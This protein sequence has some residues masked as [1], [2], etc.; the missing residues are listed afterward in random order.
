MCHVVCHPEG[1]VSL[2]I[3]EKI[4]PK[5][6][7]FTEIRTRDSFRVCDRSSCNLF[8]DSN[9]FCL[10]AVLLVCLVLELRKTSSAR[11]EPRTVFGVVAF[12]SVIFSSK[13][14]TLVLAPFFCRTSY[15]SYRNHLHGDNF[16]GFWFYFC[17]L[18]FRTKNFGLGAILLSCLV[19]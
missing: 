10:G 16:S 6:K 2:N 17:N 9:K 12:V 15:P 4:I 11:L 1:H 8:S 13:Q 7:F 19:S 5:P 18:L 14:T 3:I